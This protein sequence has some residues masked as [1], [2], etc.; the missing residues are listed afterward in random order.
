M[1][2]GLV[3]GDEAMRDALAASLA[4]R[5]FETHVFNGIVILLGSETKADLDCLVVDLRTAEAKQ[6]Q[7]AAGL[8]ERLRSDGIAIPTIV[9]TGSPAVSARVRDDS[10]FIPLVKPVDP[11]ILSGVLKTVRQATSAARAKP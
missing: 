4:L 2:V 9:L 5:G 6:E 7:E 3:I 11:N 8:E 10:P 1:K